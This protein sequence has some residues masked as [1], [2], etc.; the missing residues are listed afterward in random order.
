M[1]TTTKLEI[2][3]NES[4]APKSSKHKFRK[5]RRVGFDNSHEPS[6]TKQSFK[7]ECDINHILA[8]HSMETLRMGQA[9]NPGKFDDFTQ[10][11]DYPTALNAIM[12]A[13][14]A[15]MTLPAKVRSRFN[16]DPQEFLEFATNVKNQDEWVTLGLATYRPG[17]APTKP[18]VAPAKPKPKTPKGDSS[19][20]VDE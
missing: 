15:F 17:E 19:T 16:N 3:T 2:T 12:K 5:R 8:R 13:E 20:S 4:K 6:L 18:E 9:L 1:A 10:V 14:D 7:T 11:V